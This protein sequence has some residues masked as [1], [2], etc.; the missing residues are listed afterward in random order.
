MHPR[1]TARQRAE[2]L[3][4]PRAPQ[5]KAPSPF[6]TIKAQAARAHG[7]GRLKR[8]GQAAPKRDLFSLGKAA[9]P[10]ADRGEV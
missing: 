3:F 1:E 6:E 5:A 8:S 4:K 2:A 9:E 10:T 7:M